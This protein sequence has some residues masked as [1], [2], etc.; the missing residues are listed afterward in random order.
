MIYLLIFIL[1]FIIFNIFH[2]FYREESN[3]SELFFS[4]ALRGGDSFESVS[5]K[6]K[7]VLFIHGYPGS[8]KMYYMVREFAIKS[9]YD[10]FVPRLPGFASKEEEF[11]KTNFSMWY[12]FVRDFYVGKR[13]DYKDFYIV[14]NSMGGALALKLAQE[15]SCN[16]K[17]RPTAVTSL[18]APVFVG[19]IEK[20]ILRTIKIFVTYIPP[21]NGK[22]D[23]NDEDGDSEWVGYKGV[24][25]K[26]AY[27]LLVGLRGIK[28]D[29]KK[30]T[31]PYYLC[32]AKGD[33]TVPFKNLKYIYN[34]I[35]S[36]DIMVRVMDLSKWNHTNHSMFIYKSIAPSIWREID[37]FFREFES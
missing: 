1:L 16:E 17:F 28:R 4:E 9:G 29:L 27:S 37:T 34:R 13:L 35:S 10:V 32:H 24:F 5:G 23:K 22:K 3:Y 2:V 25:P 12:R 33:R 20:Y 15:F 6:D 19:N 36:S 14:G 30:I 7:A 11:I 8:P 18:A 21:K 31:V 26:Q